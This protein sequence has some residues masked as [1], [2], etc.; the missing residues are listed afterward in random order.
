MLQ[1]HS[2]LEYLDHT[3]T[4]HI[5]RFIQRAYDRASHGLMAWGPFLQPTEALDV[6]LSLL[7]DK[8]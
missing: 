8:F 5:L 2:R 4:G 6:S 1:N 3:T 7:L